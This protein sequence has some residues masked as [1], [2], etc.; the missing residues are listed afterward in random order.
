MIIKNLKLKIKNWER[1]Q[2]LF[3]VVVAIAISALMIVTLVSLVSNSI[4]NATFSK[5]NAQA[6]SYGQQATE[7]LRTERD[8]N[9]ATFIVNTTTGTWCLKD[10]TWT[11][12][13]ACLDTQNITGTPFLREGHFVS[14][15]VGGKTVIEADIV[16][17]WTDAQGLHQVTS[18]TNFT[19]WRQR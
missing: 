1:G 16:V 10:L 2:S 13:G 12:T 7:W 9:I 8:N 18:A 5:N 19:D 6:A 3:E 17:S 4:R 15:L 14:T 11:I